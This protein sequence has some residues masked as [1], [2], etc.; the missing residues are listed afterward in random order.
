GGG[1]ALRVAD[2]GGGARGDGHCRGEVSI[3][4]RRLAPPLM[5]ALPPLQP[6]APAAAADRDTAGPFDALVVVNEADLPALLDSGTLVAPSLV[7]AADLGLD[8]AELAGVGR[9]SEDSVLTPRDL[10]LD[11]PA[12]TVVGT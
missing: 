7:R 8:E 2:W 12:P 3:Y 10:G 9:F 1:G 11:M 4:V 6:V 5:G